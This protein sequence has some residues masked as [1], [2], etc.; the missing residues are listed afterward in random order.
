[1]T[2]RDR[3]GIIVRSATGTSMKIIDGGLDDPRV[4]A[5]LRHHHATCHAVTPAGS[6]HALD[7]S[8]LR[9]PAIRFWSVWDG[10]TVLGVGALKRL[11]DDHGPA[12]PRSYKRSAVQQRPR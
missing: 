2:S 6:A 3:H 9:V 1:V 7:L 5:L 4:V 8:G 11:S 12:E 10:E